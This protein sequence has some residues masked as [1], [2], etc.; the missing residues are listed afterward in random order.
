MAFFTFL[1]LGCAVTKEY[2]ATGGSRAD[3]IIKLSYEQRRF[4]IPNI[5]E[6]QGL[7]LAR[8][9]CKSWGYNDAQS[10]GGVIRT[11]NESGLSSCEQWL[12]TKDYQCLGNLEK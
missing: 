8:D 11:C 7:N 5:N 9:R 2:A 1:L 10:F 4:E 6:Q 12:I 3:G